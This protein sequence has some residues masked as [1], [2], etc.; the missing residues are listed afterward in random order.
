MD[1][2]EKEKNLI[3]EYLKSNPLLTGGLDRFQKL[4]LLSL[5]PRSDFLKLHLLMGYFEIGACVCTSSQLNMQ[6]QEH[7]MKKLGYAKCKK[8]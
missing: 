2:Y 1:I 4:L 5:D 6:K 7:L 3:T 8:L